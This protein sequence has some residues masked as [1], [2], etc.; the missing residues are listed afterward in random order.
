MSSVLIWILIGTIAPLIRP[1]S[2]QTFVG[3]SVAKTFASLFLAW[4][5][6]VS[7]EK[8][9]YRNPVGTLSQ[10]LADG[11][12]Y[13]GAILAWVVIVDLTI[14]IF[15]LARHFVRPTEDRPVRIIANS[16]EWAVGAVPLF[17]WLLCI[18]F[19]WDYFSKNP[20]GA[21]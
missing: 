16:F 12:F 1:A 7:L 11:D 19:G 10:F 8:W 21:F 9:T 17:L 6:W 15:R 5:T 20:P 2:H 3:G 4:I 14:A 13:T 18:P